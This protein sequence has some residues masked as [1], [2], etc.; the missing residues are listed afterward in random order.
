MK[1]Q[2]GIHAEYGKTEY[3]FARTIKEGCE[4]FARLDLSEDEHNDYLNGMERAMRPLFYTIIGLAVLVIAAQV[5]G[6]VA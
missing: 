6:G 4:G 2:D 5:W 1:P 3:R